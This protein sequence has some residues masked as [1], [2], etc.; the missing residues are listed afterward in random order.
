MDCVRICKE[1]EFQLMA[2]ELEDNT[3]GNWSPSIDSTTTT[4]SNNNSTNNT[5]NHLLLSEFDNTLQSGLTTIRTS[6]KNSGFKLVKKYLSCL[7]T[8]SN[9]TS[10]IQA[11]LPFL[12]CC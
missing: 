6:L 2:L 3:P 4:N 5:N 9:Q 12:D 8:Y 1:Q 7:S 11:I 10:N